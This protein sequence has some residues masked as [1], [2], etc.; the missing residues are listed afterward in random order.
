MIDFLN[1]FLDF[2]KVSIGDWK[3][4]IQIIESMASCL[5]RTSAFE[6][7]FMHIGSGS[8]GKST[9]L[10]LL[11]KMLGRQNVAHMSPHQLERERFATAELEGKMLNVYADIVSETLT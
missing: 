9:F 11:E 2:L 8:N 7:A 1:E 6:K 4:T 3:Q 5:L 10:S